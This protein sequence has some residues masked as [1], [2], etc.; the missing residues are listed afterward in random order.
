M[1]NEMNI[2]PLTSLALCAAGVATAAFSS[3][4]HA[5][6]QT[7]ERV[8][9]A[10]PRAGAGQVVTATRS[11]P[12]LT[13]DALEE[14]VAAL[15]ADFV[16]AQSDLRAADQ[17]LRA[18][19][20][21]ADKTAA[22]GRVADAQRRADALERELRP[23][24]RRF[25]VEKVRAELQK[26]I[27]LTLKD[28][29]LEQMADA[30]APVSRVQVQIDPALKNTTRITLDARRV[31]LA[32]VLE[33][34]ARRAEV[35]IEPDPDAF[36]TNQLIV[37]LVPPPSLT[38]NGERAPRPQTPQD[39]LSYP[40][41]GEWYGAPPT[42]SP[43]GISI[44]VA[45]EAVRSGNRVT[46]GPRTHYSLS[47]LGTASTADKVAIGGG[48]ARATGAVSATVAPS[49]SGGTQV[50]VTPFGSLTGG[51]AQ[52]VKSGQTLRV[53][54]TRGANG[55]VT[56]R[57][58][59]T[60]DSAAAALRFQMNFLQNRLA[61]LTA[62]RDSKRPNVKRVEIDALERQ[63]AELKVQQAVRN[64][65]ATELRAS[66]TSKVSPSPPTYFVIGKVDRSGT[67]MTTGI[68]VKDDELTVTRVG[69]NDKNESGEFV[70]VYEINKTDGTL[71]KK[72]GPTFRKNGT[73][74]PATPFQKQGRIFDALPRGFS[75]RAPVVPVQPLP[76]YLYAPGA[77]RN[78]IVPAPTPQRPLPNAATP[79]LRWSVPGYEWRAPDYEWNAPNQ[80]WLPKPWFQLLGG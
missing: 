33:A 7:E 49:V 60:T 29:S 36:A 66:S 23:L 44:N 35:F 51:F 24:A 48:V 4:A 73:F 30:L 6:Q 68:S 38:I 3:P 55:V 25:T 52:M 21:N 53:E 56:L 20:E 5:Q 63:L 26:P 10:A 14:R 31:P 57:V 43:I 58:S 41:T 18:L 46:S 15:S 64:A 77:S 34:I 17:A 32:E 40:W 61:L 69:K 80:R 79:S 13:G 72:S 22:Q 74:T 11:A 47:A 2:L 19:P 50:V 42:N 45:T 1:K 8:A 16:K 37:S 71:R 39:T 70:T 62:E 12:P 78:F 59:P 65:A 67:T 54:Q 28:A 75:L 9:A 27:S 76:P